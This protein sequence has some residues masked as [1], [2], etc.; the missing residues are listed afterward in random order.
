MSGDC[1]S[2]LARAVRDML[3]PHV[4]TRIALLGDAQEDR[5]EDLHLLVEFAPGAPPI[6]LGEWLRVQREVGRRCGC[7]AELVSVTRLEERVAS[8]SVRLTIL[9][10]GSAH[11]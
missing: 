7:S 6:F 11:S 9:Y 2:C 5:R 10:D 3:G 1:L 4:V 8:E